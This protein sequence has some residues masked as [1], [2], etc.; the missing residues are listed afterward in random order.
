MTR[1]PPVDIL[2]TNRLA[3]VGSTSNS[4]TKAVATG[5]PKAVA[6]ATCHADQAVDLAHIHRLGTPKKSSR[7]P[8]GADPR[9]LEGDLRNQ[10]RCVAMNRATKLETVHG[11][12]TIKERSA[13]GPVVADS[14]PRVDTNTSAAEH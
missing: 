5:E 11:P 10:I 1:L 6:S 12:G 9:W 13:P 8:S 14:P 2:H 3:G 7:G 4:E